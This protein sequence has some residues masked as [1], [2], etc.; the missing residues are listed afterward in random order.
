[1]PHD[2][3]YTIGMTQ[4]TTAR[5]AIAGQADIRLT[6]TV[7]GVY[8]VTIA[9]ASTGQVVH[10]W[11]TDSASDAETGFLR[12]VYAFGRGLTIDAALDLMGQG[13]V[14]P[15][16]STETADEP[17]VI[18]APAS[19]GQQTAMSRA[20]AHV[21]AEATAGYIRRGRGFGAASIAQLKAMAK[22]DFVR[23][24]VRA[25]GGRQF[26]E[27]GTVT[28]WGQRRADEVMATT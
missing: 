8:V 1:M 22:R 11:A 25:V 12:R 10:T 4:T 7:T 18:L 27:G 16:A 24:D 23:L 2:V 13:G 15:S 14:T 3:A 17:V 19:K 9:Y 28:T 5:K 20:Q 21:I 6:T 26:I